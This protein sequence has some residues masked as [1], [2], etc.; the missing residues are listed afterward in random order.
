MERFR[1]RMSGWF[2][3]APDSDDEWVPLVDP[4]DPAPTAAD[5]QSDAFIRG[6]EF[7]SVEIV[8]SFPHTEVVALFHAA[9]RA[10]I[11]F[12]RRWPLYDDLGNPQPLEYAGIHLME[13]I[14]AA[15][16]G[17]PGLEACVPDDDGLVSS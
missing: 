2:G 12:G 1:S 11:Q 10:G 5:W 3:R 13:D 6:V 17:L 7:D 4:S 14:E 15:G 8:G 16:Y 9:D